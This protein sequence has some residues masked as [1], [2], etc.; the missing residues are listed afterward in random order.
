[1]PKR[2][3]APSILNAD[4]GQ[5]AETCA[6]LESEGVEIL[7]LDVMDGHF[8]PNLTFGPVVAKAIRKHSSLRIE[9]HLMVTCPELLIEPFA[10]AGCQRILVH[11]EGCLHLDRLLG[12]IREAGAE[13]GVVLNPATSLDS[14]AEVLPQLRQVLI[15]SVNPGFGGQSF[16]PYTLEKVRR[17]VAWNEGVPRPVDIEIDGGV[18]EETLPAILDAGATH[19]VIGSAIFGA[20]DPRKATAEFQ[21]RLAERTV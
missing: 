5:L 15:M 8:V 16:I 4:L 1:M 12:S 20:E 2:F 21:R 6:M 17:L 9:A 14:I 13:P 19:L 11:P 3:L 7:H 18:N 10:R